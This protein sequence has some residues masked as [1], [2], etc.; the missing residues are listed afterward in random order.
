MI[1]SGISF[2]GWSGVRFGSF[3]WGLGDADHAALHAY[4]APFPFCFCF[5]LYFFSSSSKSVQWW[6]WR[7]CQRF[8]DPYFSPAPLKSVQWWWCPCTACVRAVFLTGIFCLA[9]SVWLS[10]ISP[11]PIG[12]RPFFFFLYLILFPC[13][14]STLHAMQSHSSSD[15][16]HPHK[17]AL[18][19]SWTFKEQKGNRLAF[20]FIYF[21]V[22]TCALLNLETHGQIYTTKTSCR[23]IVGTI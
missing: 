2:G 18:D 4:T 14:A 12:R 13:F 10:A 11:C 16:G 19:S 20:Y 8:F 17:Q 21:Y 3:P 9:P 15:I 22:S 5:H 1:R 23:I 6:A 7:A